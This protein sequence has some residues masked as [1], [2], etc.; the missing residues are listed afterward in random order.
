MNVSSLAVGQKIELNDGRVAQVRFVGTTHFQTGDWVGVQLEEATGKNDGSVKGERY[1][2][3]E[4]GYGM[5]LRPAGVRQVVED[6]KP[7]A[8]PGVAAKGRP[9]S[10]AHS[11]V[12]GLKRQE[13]GRRQSNV[14]ASPTPGARACYYI[15]DEYSAYQEAGSR[16]YWYSCKDKDKH[17]PYNHPWCEQ[18]DLHAARN[19]LHCGHERAEVLLGTTYAG[20]EG[21]AEKRVSSTE[22]STGDDNDSERPSERSPRETESPTPSP[23]EEGEQETEEP[24]KPNFAPP[25]I[26]SEPPQQ[27]SRSRRPSSPTAA[28]THSGR[29]IRSTAASNRQIEELEAKVRLLERKRQEDRDVQKQLEQAHQERDQYK[30]IIEKLQTKVRPLQHENAELKQS[31][32][33]TEARFADIEAIQAEHDSVMELATLDRE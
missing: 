12:N 10:G 20:Y 33:E 31:L 32:N 7:K 25:P 21:P 9:V 2:D 18:T 19:N 1:F 3:C 27:T 6:A 23:G 29:T 17:W 30:G 15:E 8:R 16:S 24:A 11:A 14:P 13:S 28:S 5:F 22:H 26:P 4:Q